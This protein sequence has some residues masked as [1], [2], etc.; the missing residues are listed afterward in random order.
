MSDSN[1]PVELI[2]QEYKFTPRPVSIKLKWRQKVQ[3]WAQTNRG[4]VQI[5]RGWFGRLHRWLTG[6]KL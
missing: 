6:I 1:E 5:Y 3:M 2:V 4:V